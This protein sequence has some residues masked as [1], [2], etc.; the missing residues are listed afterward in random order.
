MWCRTTRLPV[1]TLE[2]TSTLKWAL[3]AW[4]VLVAGMFSR[5]NLA[6]RDLVWKFSNV[7]RLDPSRDLRTTRS[8]RFL[9]SVV[10]ST[11]TNAAPRNRDT[12][13]RATSPAPSRTAAGSPVTFPS[14]SSDA[15]NMGRAPR[16]TR[17]I[18][19]TAG[20]HLK[21]APSEPGRFEFFSSDSLLPTHAPEP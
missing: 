17:Q 9:T 12:D 8:P 5:H 16:P 15:L 19:R 10:C 1:T 4:L 14:L 6:L 18:Q 2:V 21:A 13:R 7:N 11:G 20:V 3:A